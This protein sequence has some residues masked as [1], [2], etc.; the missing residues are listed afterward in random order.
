MIVGSAPGMRS[1]MR[2]FPLA[3]LTAVMTLS[4]GDAAYAAVGPLSGLKE[5]SYAG[6]TVEVP[7]SWP[8]RDLTAD[9]H[10]CIRYDQH[11]V[12][13]GDPGPDQD[14]AAGDRKSVV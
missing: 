3:A 2:L 1:V 9:P 5:V 6:S 7:V 8:V 14:C 4:C 10:T 12:Y 11:A 13:L